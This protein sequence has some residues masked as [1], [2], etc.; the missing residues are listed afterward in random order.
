MTAAAL[1]MLSL[2]A[3]LLSDLVLVEPAVP[4]GTP[5]PAR[6]ADRPDLVFACAASNDLYRILSRG[7]SPLP[8]H[9]GAAAAVAAARPGAGVL[10]LADGYP[11]SPARIEPSVLDEARR[12]GLRLYIEFP[13]S[14]PRLEVGEPRG[15]G[16]ERAVV[17]SDAFG[18]DLERLRI[19]ALGSCRFVPV[20]GKVETHLVF[21]RVAGFDRAVYG[22]PE[23]GVLPVLFEEGGV[24]V[25][26]TKLSDFVRARYAPADAWRAVWSFILKRLAPGAEP[27]PLEW[28]PAVRPSFGRDEAVPAQVEALA[29]RR[30]VAWFTNGRMLVHPSWADWMAKADAWKDRVGPLPGVA[31]GA[32]A[33]GGDAPPPG[34]GS[35]GMIEGFSS[36]IFPDGSQ[37]VRWAF[38]ADCTGEAAMA[39]ALFAAAAGDDRGAAV[40]RNLLEHLWVRSGL[41]GGPR[42]DPASPSYGLLGWGAPGS[43]HIYFGDDNARALLGTMAAAASLRTDRWDEPLLRGIL[44]NFRT[45]GP[46][47]FR[48]DALVEADLQKQGWRHFF[49]TPTVVHAPHY[50]SWLWACYLWAHARTGF[51]PLLERSKAAIRST[52]SAYPDRWRWTNGMQQ[53]RA[54]MLLPIAWLVR[55]EK[56]DEHLAWLR[57]MAADLVSLQDPSGALREEIGAIERGQLIPPRSNE[58][59]GTGETPILHENGDPV[60]DLLYTSNFAF[61][62]LHEAAAAT[63]DPYYAEAEE[64]LA[65]FLCRI[66]VKSEARPELDGAWYRAFDFRRWEYWG[67]NGDAGW[68]AWSVETG[69]T[70]GW[71]VATLALRKMK[72]SLWDLTAPSR[73]GELMPSLRPAMIPDEDLVGN[74]RRDKAVPSPPN[75]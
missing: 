57:K 20:G 73:A 4:A 41:A 31:R 36:T 63:G 61:I 34:D 48:G 29:L 26:T 16:W 17:A 64:R 33:S 58:A 15:L 75:K 27:P 66:Q 42:A 67:A 14:L 59:Y 56:T 3:G 45:A 47:G 24:L 49:R 55:V 43:L 32:E 65:K 11:D 1:A 53:E 19:L 74:G 7:G 5:S 35:L 18:K 71:I 22:L 6:D 40:A 9:E 13:A 54:R 37:P 2:L 30:G 52:I 62:G 69:W 25:A 44:A 39:H 23:K 38:R 72:T 8:R 21:A 10:I 68:G 28:T 46:L 51:A 12:K 50:Q 70:Q 60:C